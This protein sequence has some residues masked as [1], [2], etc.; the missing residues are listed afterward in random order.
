LAV[1]YY[2]TNHQPVDLM[3]EWLLWLPSL[4]QTCGLCTRCRADFVTSF[5]YRC[6]MA[7]N[8]YATHQLHFKHWSHFYQ[9]YLT[10]SREAGF[11]CSSWNNNFAADPWIGQCSHE[12]PARS[13]SGHPTTS[14][15]AKK[16][17]WKSWMMSS[18]MLA[19]KD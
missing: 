12:K 19:P 14:R 7:L 16:E 10:W 15:P 2:A 8:K 5:P 3:L 18:W 1:V 17:R 13:T 11:F 9:I 6:A 4:V